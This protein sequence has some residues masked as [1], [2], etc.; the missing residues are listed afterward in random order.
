MCDSNTF[1]VLPF[2]YVTFLIHQ[3][4]ASELHIQMYITHQMKFMFTSIFDINYC[5]PSDATKCA[6]GRIYC[7]MD[8]NTGHLPHYALM[9][10]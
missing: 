10:T 6:L 4:A 9:R 2:M 3:E 5:T 1:E 7:S 8:G